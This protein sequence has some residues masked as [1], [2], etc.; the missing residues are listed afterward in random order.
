MLTLRAIVHIDI[1]SRQCADRAQFSVSRTVKRE[2]R[3]SARVIYP[4][5]R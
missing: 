2:R 3:E 5:W 1:F 4:A